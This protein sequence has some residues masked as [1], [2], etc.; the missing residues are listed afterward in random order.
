MKKAG[1]LLRGSPRGGEGEGGGREGEGG[2]DSGPI[3][4]SSLRTTMSAG[5]NKHEPNDKR[6]ENQ[7]LDVQK[8]TRQIVSQPEQILT[9]SAISSIT[10]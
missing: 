5:S 10:N 2:P 9:N 8:E 1:N 3:K 4:I 6:K 7:A